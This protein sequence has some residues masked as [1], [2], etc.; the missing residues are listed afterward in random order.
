MITLVRIPSWWGIRAAHPENVMAPLD[1]GYAAALLLRAGL[2]VEVLDVEASGADFEEVTSALARQPPE[3]VVLQMITPAVPQAE[4]L[5][6]FVKDR[7]PGVRQIIAVG[8]HATVLPET[9]LGPGAAFD[10]CIRGEYEYKLAEVITSASPEPEGLARRGP[11]GAPEVDPTILQ[12]DALDALPLPAHHLFI[13]P[14]YRVFH[15]TGVKAR[16]RWG[17]LLSSRGCP[18]RC[19]YC[20]PTLRNSHGDRFRYR[21]ADS[22][23]EELSLL[24]GLGC[25]LVHFKDDV[26]TQNR[27]RVVQLCEAILARG[28]RIHWTVQTRPDLVDAGLLRLMKRAGCVTVGFGVESGSQRV[29]DRLKKQ[30]DVEDVRRAF[31]MARRAGL[32]TVGFFMLGN[33][34]ETEQDIRLTHRLLLEVAP[35]I[36]QVAFFTAYPGAEVFDQELLRRFSLEQFSHYNVP[37]NDSEVSRSR[38]SWWQRKLYLDFLLRTGFIP[39]YLRNQALPSL[40][41]IEKFAELARLSLRFFGKRLAL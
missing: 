8:Q 12:V 4:R 18:H 15:P 35:D 32:L 38:L 21:D 7:L 23:L 40:I 14:R 41:N 30:L 20:S 16:W 33:P 26:F 6:R 13:S 17:F 11:D 25:T 5:A 36:I 1:M 19:V 9:L 28:E 37:M 27:E 24:Q 10:L 3:Q 29:L 34:G 39:R 31:A 2:D 22:V